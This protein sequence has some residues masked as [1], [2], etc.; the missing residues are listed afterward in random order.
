MKRLRAT[1]SVC[2]ALL[3]S[4]A[5]LAQDA[6]LTRRRA[7]SLFRTGRYE[8]A[9]SLYD[10]LLF[11]DAAGPG[12]EA[13][14]RLAVS[15]FETGDFNRAARH[16]DAAYFAADTDSLREE[17]LLRK[18]LS[19]LL[20]QRPQEALIE[21]LSLP[22]GTDPHRRQVYLGLTYF[23]LRDYEPAEAA[24]LSVVP[25]ERHAGVREVFRRA[26]RAE[27]RFR[28]GR[29][30]WMSAFAPGLGQL[31]VG[32]V[33][34]GINSAAINGAFAYLFVSTTL[35]YGI[36]SAFLT[37]LPWFQRYYFG[38]IK[39][40]GVLATQRGDNRRRALYLELVDALEGDAPPE[41]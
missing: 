24:L 21:L 26:R 28:P 40:V 31:Y 41:E 4:G 8:A 7:D 2:C 34:S 23:L 15:Y 18:G 5:A 35:N 17:V 22:A 1:W 12:V 16:Y 10:R 13:N 38:G 30:Q 9:I 6:D 32:D 14:L 37:V 19:Y 39:K 29:A 33:R 11:F 25:P 20:A 3:L 27:R 36:G